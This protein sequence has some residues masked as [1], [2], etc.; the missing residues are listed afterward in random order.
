LHDLPNNV[1]I[2]DIAVFEVGYR[3]GGKIIWS[4]RAQVGKPFR[5]TPVFRDKIRYLEINSTWTEPPTILR[6][7]ILLQLAKDPG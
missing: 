1:V 4:A 3:R 6:N 2:T 7:D 5:K